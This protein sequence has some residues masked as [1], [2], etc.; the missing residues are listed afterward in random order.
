MKDTLALGTNNRTTGSLPSC[1]NLTDL[2]AA[3]EPASAPALPFFTGRWSCHVATR[4]GRVARRGCRQP[5]P[6]GRARILQS[7]LFDLVA[8]GQRGQAFEHAFEVGDELFETDFNAQDGVGARVG[9]GQRFS[10]VPRADLNGPG[11]WAAHT[12]ARAT[13]P[14]GQSCNSCHAVPSRRRRRRHQQ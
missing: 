12:P 3:A 11:E 4:A 7:E 10:R 14:N 8:A 1:S 9:D 2:L 6:P 5:R 13:G